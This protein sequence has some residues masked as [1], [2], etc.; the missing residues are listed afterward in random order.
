LPVCKPWL[1]SEGIELSG[2]V[3]YVVDG[4]TL[5]VND[6]RVRLALVDTPE[7]GENGYQ[8]AKNFVKNLCL[9]DDAEVDIDDGQRGGDRYAREIGVVYCDGVNVNSELIE[10]E[11]AIIFTEYCDLSEFANEDWAD[12]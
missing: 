9:G 1:L 10:Q 11:H 5:D 8:S 6:I 2:P 3:T 4:D 12:C 7:R